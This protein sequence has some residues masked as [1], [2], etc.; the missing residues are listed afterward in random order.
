M[1]YLIAILY[2]L[3]SY[4]ITT[5]FIGLIISAVTGEL[6]FVVGYSPD[7]RTWPGNILGILIGIYAAKSSFNRVPRRNRKH[8]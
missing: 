2:F 8:L 7:W 5:A 3:V 6:M 4:C 1:K